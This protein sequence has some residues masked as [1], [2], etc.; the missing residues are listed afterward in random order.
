MHIHPG[1]NYRMT[2]HRMPTS[3]GVIAAD[4]AAIFEWRII[5]KASHKYPSSVDTISMPQFPY[6]PSC[7]SPV[8]LFIVYLRCYTDIYL[9][10]LR[11]TTKKPQS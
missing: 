4:F 10:E 2:Y 5:R 6:L 1:K 8:Y 9:E 3:E 11:E 7:H